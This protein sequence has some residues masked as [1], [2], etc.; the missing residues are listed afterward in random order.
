MRQGTTLPFAVAFLVG[1]IAGMGVATES[2]TNT[3]VSEQT[4]S[5]EEELT[6]NNHILTSLLFLL[7]SA[8]DLVGEA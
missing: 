7:A 2:T 8:T 1:G 6:L 3:S 4:G 5:T